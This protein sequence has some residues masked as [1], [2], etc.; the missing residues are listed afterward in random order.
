MPADDSQA[1]SK[2]ETVHGKM[3]MEAKTEMK[4]KP[5]FILRQVVGEYMLMPTDDNIGVFKGVVLFN[6]T[7]AFAW[8]KM[9][10]DVSRAD[11]V[12]AMVKE[13]DADE[14]TVSRDLD[15]LLDKL[16]QLNLIEN[17]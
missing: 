5:G 14:A 9:Q 2:Y 13:F 6:S 1:G 17:A 4:A 8:E 7:S 15:L 16:N 12:A 11:L 10:E 3:K